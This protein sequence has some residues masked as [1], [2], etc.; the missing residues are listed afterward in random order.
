MPKFVKKSGSLYQSVEV[1]EYFLCISQWKFLSS[2]CQLLL[3]RLITSGAWFQAYQLVEVFEYSL[4]YQSVEVFEYSLLKTSQV[5]KTQRFR[6]S[7]V[8]P[9][10]SFRVLFVL[11]L[12]HLIGE[13][14]NLSEP[15]GI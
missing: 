6:E 5:P 11:A 15:F 4:L 14:Q 8:S 2:F 3:S 7:S 13:P 10:G 1:F 12:P 9:W